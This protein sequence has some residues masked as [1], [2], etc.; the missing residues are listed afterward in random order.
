M[1]YVV[2]FYRKE[3]GECPVEL[4]IDSL[5][6]KLQAKALRV[7]NM[8]KAYGNTLREPYSKPLKGGIFELR[9]SFGS[10]TIRLLYFFSD[11]H[12]VVLTNGFAKKTQKTPPG[13]IEMALRYKADWIRRKKNG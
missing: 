9:T 8:L 1:G 2:D 12:L 7:I 4:F 10:D 5:D 13:E 11:G 6:M 3:N